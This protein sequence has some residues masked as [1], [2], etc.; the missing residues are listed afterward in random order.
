MALTGYLGRSRDAFKDCLGGASG[1]LAEI[2]EDQIPG[3]LRL[4]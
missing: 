1:R 4:E 3:R 2:F